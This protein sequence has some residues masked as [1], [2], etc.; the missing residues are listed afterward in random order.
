MTSGWDV[1]R[2]VRGRWCLQVTVMGAE[3]WS[4]GQP[5]PGHHQIRTMLLIIGL[6]W[7]PVFLWLGWLCMDC[8]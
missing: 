1:I 3:R 5:H 8:E 4:H 2:D 6:R 7:P